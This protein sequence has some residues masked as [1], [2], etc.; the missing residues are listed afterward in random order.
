M[1]TLKFRPHLCEKILDGS[2]TVTWRLFDDKDLKEGD[3][4]SLLNWET[5]KEIGRAVIEWVKEKTLA[6]MGEEDFAAGHE[7]Y[8]SK[9]EML[10]AYKSYYGDKVEWNTPVKMVKFKLV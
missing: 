10:E 7:R 4:L 9:E 8:E 5:G 1:K 6:E 2:K 3:D